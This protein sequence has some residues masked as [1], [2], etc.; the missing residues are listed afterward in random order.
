MLS[1]DL[2]TATDLLDCT[3]TGKPFQIDG[4]ATRQ[5]R[6]ANWVLT[7]GTVNCWMHGDVVLQALQF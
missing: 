6:L 3:L 1:L 7:L 2:K 4:A 5:A